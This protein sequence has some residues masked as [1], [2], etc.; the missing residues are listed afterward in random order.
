MQR[1]HRQMILPNFGKEGQEKLHSSRVLVIGAGGLGVPVLQYLTAAGIG[2]IGIVDHDNID[3]TN[4]HRQVLYSENE[5]GKSKAA[6]AHQKMQK[7][8]SEIHIEAFHSSISKENAFDIISPFDIIIDCTDNFPT[9]YLVNDACFL[10]NKTLIYGAIY[11]WEGQVSVFNHNGSGNYRDLFPHPPK[12]DE[13]PNCEE[14]GVLGVLPGII[15]SLMANECIKIITEIGEIL[16][17]KLLIFDAKTN[18]TQTIKFRSRKDNPLSGE[19]PE[20]KKLIDYEKFCGIQIIESNG[21][22]ISPE[23]LKKWQIEERE[24]QLI[25]VREKDEYKVH[26]IGGMNLPLSKIKSLTHEIEDDIPVVLICQTGKRS[27][28]VLQFLKKEHDFDNLLSL[29]GGIKAY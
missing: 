25:D 13:V 17:N 5:V 27:L 18:A 14:G 11:R 23:E 10:L 7:L 3:I 6:V 8:N 1:Y 29:E 22:L 15:G 19:N 20:I 4:L 9:R 21:D 26:N 2:H 16:A 24:F 12:P 28:S